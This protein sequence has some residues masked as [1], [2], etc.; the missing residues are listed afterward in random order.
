[1]TLE[2]IKAYPKEMITPQMA[3]SVIGCDPHYIRVAAKQNPEKLGFTTLVSGN[4]VK[5]PRR[6]FIRFMEGT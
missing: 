6:S 3:A 4:R 1:M 2:E 5:I